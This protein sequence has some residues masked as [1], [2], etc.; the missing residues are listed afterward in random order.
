[1]RSPLGNLLV[2]GQAYIHHPTLF[3]DLR[4]DSNPWRIGSSPFYTLVAVG[5]VESVAVPVES[6]GADQ[7]L[8]KNIRFYSQSPYGPGN[9]L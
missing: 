4:S 8:Y 3:T 2:L 1:M 6:D 9:D 7:A 5:L